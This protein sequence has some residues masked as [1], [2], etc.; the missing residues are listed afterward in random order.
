MIDE[1]DLEPDYYIDRP[2]TAVFIP[3]P[4]GEMKMTQIFD[5]DPDLFDYN[6]EVEPIL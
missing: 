5:G 1:Y 6:N 2:P 4:K 3:N